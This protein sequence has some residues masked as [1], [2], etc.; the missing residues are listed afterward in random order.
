VNASLA[1][2]GRSSP[3]ARRTSRGTT[4]SW[5]VESAFG[6]HAAH[7]ARA[8]AAPL[9]SRRHHKRGAMF[10][11]SATRSAARPRRARPTGRRSTDPRGDRSRASPA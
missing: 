8:R 5:K 11:Q 7:S 10:G 6:S 9:R 4:T 1:S 2:Y 3:P